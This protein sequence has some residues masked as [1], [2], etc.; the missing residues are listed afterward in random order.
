MQQEHLIP[1][2]LLRVA[3]AAPLVDEVRAPG[4]AAEG[5]K[6][7]IFPRDLAKIYTNSIIQI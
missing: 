4:Q 7:K 1:K 6:D 3:D 2:E 5:T